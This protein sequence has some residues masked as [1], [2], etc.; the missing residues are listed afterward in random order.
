MD[1]RALAGADRRGLDLGPF[2]RDEVAV[3]AEAILGRP[4]E[5]TLVDELV[6]RAGGNAFITEELLA[7]LDQAGRMP[8]STGVTQVLLARVATL[9]R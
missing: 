3:Q 1:R 8:R 9:P 5:Q 4:P 6:Q 7:S 2:G